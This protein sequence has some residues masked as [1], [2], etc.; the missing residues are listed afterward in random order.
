MGAQS[1][2][3]SLQFY[4]I[5]LG[6]HYPSITAL[7]P[8]P[9]TLS[10]K[11]PPK[12]S[13]WL[14]KHSTCSHGPQPPGSP[15]TGSSLWRVLRPLHELPLQITMAAIPSPGAWQ[16]LHEVNQN[17]LSRGSRSL[18]Q[19]SSYVFK[20]EAFEKMQHKV[21]I[22][23]LKSKEWRPSGNHSQANFQSML[24]LDQLIGGLEEPCI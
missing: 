10:R 13:S 16:E 12:G 18:V 21:P 2:W 22:L 14:T 5:I 7:L 17:K 8:F 1:N 6:F 15:R 4:G 23:D 19:F 24:L 3:K 20:S 11:V 9:Q